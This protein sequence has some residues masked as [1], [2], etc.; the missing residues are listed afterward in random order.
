METTDSSV[1]LFLNNWA[2]FRL[3][4]QRCNLRLL[5]D[6]VKYRANNAKGKQRGARATSVRE[7]R[8]S[9]YLPMPLLSFHPPL[10]CH[11][12]ILTRPLCIT[13]TCTLHDHF[14]PDVFWVRRTMC[15][16]LMTRDCHDFCSLRRPF[17][18]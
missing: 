1:S 14:Q 9:S 18:W 3:S 4:V 7:C 5:L 17:R 12:T 11:C 8:A 13:T 6:S 16:T 10:S 2:R 15:T